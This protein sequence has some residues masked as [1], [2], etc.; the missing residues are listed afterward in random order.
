MLLINV[1]VIAGVFTEEQKQRMIS[2]L[3]D[4]MVAIEGES[5]RAVTWVMIEEI[6]SGDWGIGGQRLTA[7][8]IKALA[9][10]RGRA[11]HT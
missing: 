2:R 1:K 9:A 10:D 7:G 6:K 11:G 8:N 4:A 3:T 5:L